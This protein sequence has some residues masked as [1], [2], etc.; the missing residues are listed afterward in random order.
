MAEANKPV[1]GAYVGVG[2]DTTLGGG[3]AY[4]YSTDGKN[5]IACITPFGFTFQQ[6]DALKMQALFQPVKQLQLLS[7]DGSTFNLTVADDGTLTATK[8]GET[9]GS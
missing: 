3:Q 5:F 8:E 4:G 9:S 7:P 1:A 2:V 6:S